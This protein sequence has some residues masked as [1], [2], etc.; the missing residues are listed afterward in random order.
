MGF[1]LLPWVQVKH[2]GSHLL[3]KVARRISDDWIEKYKHPIYLLE[4]FVEHRFSGTCHN[5][6]KPPSTDAYGKSGKDR[7]SSKWLLNHRFVIKTQINYISVIYMKKLL[8]TP[9]PYIPLIF[10]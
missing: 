4:T 6:S 10:I 1:L 8:I 5:S 3:G 7:E 9:F 2:L